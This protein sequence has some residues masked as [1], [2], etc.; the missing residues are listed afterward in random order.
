MVAVAMLTS[1]IVGMMSLVLSVILLS[2]WTRL[3]VLGT[4]HVGILTSARWGFWG[5]LFDGTEKVRHRTK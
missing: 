4:V 5:S 1:F 2:W 3:L